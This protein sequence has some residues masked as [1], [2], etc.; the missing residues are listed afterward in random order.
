[1]GYFLSDANE[2]IGMTKAVITK[3]SEEQILIKR[4]Y[5]SGNLK[6]MGHYE[7]H[8]EFSDKRNG[9]EIT[10]PDF[11]TRNRSKNGVASWWYENGG[12]SREINYKNGEEKGKLFNWHKNGQIQFQGNIKWRTDMA[13]IK[14]DNPKE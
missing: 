13:Q 2:A 6:F 14:T 11:V 8:D 3:L 7:M 10:L 5:P 4:Y 1:M 9:E 12:K